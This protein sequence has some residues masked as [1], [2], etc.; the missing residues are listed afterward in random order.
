M[1]LD[2]ELDEVEQRY[3]KAWRFLMEIDPM[4]TTLPKFDD[5]DDMFFAQEEKHGYGGQKVSQK[6]YRY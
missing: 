4:Q 6:A 3:P 2:E 1:T 5:N